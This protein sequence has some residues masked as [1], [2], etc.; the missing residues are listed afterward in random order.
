MSCRLDGVDSLPLTSS[1]VGTSP[2][3][4][5]TSSDDHQQHQSP[6]S[7]AASSSESSDDSTQQQQELD[8]RLLGQ[9][10]YSIFVSYW[11]FKFFFLSHLVVTSLICWSRKLWSF[12]EWS[13]SAIW[14][15]RLQQFIVSQS[16]PGIVVFYRL[17]FQWKLLRPTICII[18]SSRKPIRGTTV[19]CCWIS[20]FCCWRL[21]IET[22]SLHQFTTL[23]I[24]SSCS[25]R[26]SSR[27]SSS[28]L[29]QQQSDDR[30][31]ILRHQ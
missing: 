13:A 3:Q 18:Q 26:R 28:L 20:L 19:C 16:V 1:A 5:I 12:V 21:W 4:I 25:P 29:L 27:T 2:S 31:V 7:A 11:T 6:L 14:R 10:N 24:T 15:V 9:F 30:F 22:V 23:W 17:L 8:A